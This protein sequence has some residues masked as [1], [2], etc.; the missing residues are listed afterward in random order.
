MRKYILSVFI[1][2]MFVNLVYSQGVTINKLEINPLN[3]ALI[4]LSA[5]PDGFSTSLD[6]QKTEVIISIR[7]AKSS[8]TTPI[9]SN[10]IINSLGVVKNANQV[11][12]NAKL[13]DKRGY[14]AIY[15]PMSKSIMLEVFDWAK[16]TQS[17]DN[18]RSGMLALEDG[19]IS[20]AK[21]YFQKAANKENPNASALL[22]VILLREGKVEQ[23]HRALM[24][25]VDNKT[26]IADAYSALSQIY[27]MKAD[28]QKSVYYK[29]TFTKMTGLANYQ[30]LEMG[31][32]KLDSLSASD[33]LSFLNNWAQTGDNQTIDS[34]NSDTNVQDTNKSKV[35]VAPPET[36]EGILPQWLSPTVFYIIF[37]TL[38]ILLMLIS[39][40]FKWRKRQI[41]IINSQA[42]TQQK[43]SKFSKDL[44]QAEKQLSV[45]TKAANT[46]KQNENRTDSNMD[47]Y[48]PQ[49]NGPEKDL[50][51]EKK[52]EDN[53][54]RDL[55]RH[56]LE[57]KSFKTEKEELE[58]S[59]K[60][61]GYSK[62]PKLELALHMH[63]EQM[64]QKNKNISQL[65]NNEIP[66]D[67]NQLDDIAKKL[68][69][70]KASLSTKK[71]LS[72]LEEDKDK[73]DGLA[74]KFK[75]TKK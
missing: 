22:G 34:N 48:K 36:N 46:Y 38:L 41:E 10:G 54:V 21:D 14:S 67:E 69:I 68:G 50:K 57:S 52:E 19:I 26:N 58:R 55:A 17:E 11:S 42:N 66:A 18:Y 13:T 39:S 29:A 35:A 32:L 30:Q 47:R 6:I 15:L 72:N 56:I 37:G 59:G 75:A 64:K 70:E 51:V 4:Y 2:F 43:K 61:S 53:K 33:S 45:P 74:S 62:S 20:A 23:A 1:F 16:L 24:T 9:S 40:F 44:K 65:K 3:R 31:S 49:S 7:D 63:Q 73:L 27:N 12:I 8:L 25:A 5:Q 28:A 71:N 60:K